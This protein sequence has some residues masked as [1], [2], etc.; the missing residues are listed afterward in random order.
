MGSVIYS[1]Y[2]YLCMNADHQTA[3]VREMIM[4]TCFLEANTGHMVI[5]LVSCSTQLSMKFIGGAEARW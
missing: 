2:I 3:Y 4:C 5:Q 1:K